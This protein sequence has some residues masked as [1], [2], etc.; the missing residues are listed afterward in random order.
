MKQD[1]E[2]EVCWLLKS[3]S[4]KEVYKLFISLF[5]TDS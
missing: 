4:L 2:D 1:R 3:F 5:Q